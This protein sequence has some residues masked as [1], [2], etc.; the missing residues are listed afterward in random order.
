[1]Y[2]G[3]QASCTDNGDGTVTDNVTG[4]VW[5]QGTDTNG[6]GAMDASDKLSSEAAVS[7]CESLSLAGYDDWQLPSIKQ[8]YS[9]MDFTGTDPSGYEGADTS[10]LVPFIDTD[11]FEFAY[12]DTDAGERLIDSQY[13]SSTLY[14]SEAAVPLLFG[15]N[16]ADGRIKG[17]GTMFRGRDKTFSVACIQA[18]DSYGVND[19]ADNADG[20]VTDAATA[21]MWAQDDS[22]NDEPGGLIWEEALAYVQTQNDANYL[23][24]SDWRLPN[25]KELQSIVD[26]TRSPD[27]TDSAAIDPLFNAT[28]ITNEAGEADYSFYWSSTTHLNWTDAPG[29]AGAYVSFGRGLG[30]LDGQWSDQHGA[31]SQRSDPKAGDPDDYPTGNGPQGDAIRIYNTVR[32]VRDA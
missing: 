21:L 6:D 17:Y 13:A 22:G 15:V 3:N 32:L 20:T 23:G 30:Y 7:Y 9:L 5:T 24:H 8:L 26:Y 28:P 29:S 11:Y 4:L 16:F 18:N 1:A 19:F 27:T 10:G 2:A 12:G 31:G 25:V 14:V